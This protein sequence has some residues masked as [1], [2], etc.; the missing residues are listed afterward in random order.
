MPRPV[1]MVPLPSGFGDGRASQPKVSAAA[2][3]TAIERARLNPLSSSV[4]AVRSRKRNSTGSAFAAAASSSMNDSL[5]N[6]T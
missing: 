2:L 4:L 6:V 1:R 3:T 5:A